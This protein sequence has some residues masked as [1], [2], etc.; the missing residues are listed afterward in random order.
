MFTGRS[1]G[2][3]EGGA[4]ECDWSELG[5]GDRGGDVGDDRGYDGGC[6]GGDWSVDAGSEGGGEGGG[7]GGGEG[8]TVLRTMMSRVLSESAEATVSTLSET[9][10][11][12]SS[13]LV[14]TVNTRSTLPDSTD[15][16]T[17]ALSTPRTLATSLTI[18]RWRVSSN[19]STVPRTRRVKTVSCTMAGDGL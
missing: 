13:P 2:G 17:S 16:L 10:D 9:K 1:G 19:S 18:S 5:G 12:V 14:K 6:N 11:L 4:S 15:R 3:E 8:E 7:D